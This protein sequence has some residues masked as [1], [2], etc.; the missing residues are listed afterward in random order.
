[1]LLGSGTFGTEITNET[2]GIS[3][4]THFGVAHIQSNTFFF[5]LHN[6]GVVDVLS[7][8]A[9]GAVG[10]IV[11]T[12][13]TLV[14]DWNHMSAYTL[15]GRLMLYLYRSSDGFFESYELD[16]SGNFLG[17]FHSGYQDSGWTGIA[18]FTTTP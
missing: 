16:S 2:W 8:Q 9:S 1:M 12:I 3:A 7:I 15:D 11:G 6:S 5:R 17:L 14:T 13:G 18:H 10:N 4:Y